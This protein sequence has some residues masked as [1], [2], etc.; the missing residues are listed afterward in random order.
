MQYRAILE[1]SIVDLQALVQ[2]E[3]EQNPLLEEVGHPSAEP[4]TTGTEN[5]A[6]NLVLPDLILQ[7]VGAEYVVTINHRPIPELR[8]SEHYGHLVA[9]AGA[10]AEVRDYVRE[11]TDAAKRLIESLEQRQTAL[12]TIGRAIVEFQRDFLEN[13]SRDSITPMAL[14]RVAVLVGLE[15]TAASH[16]DSSLF[17]V[18]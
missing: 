15:E 18:E 7:Q 4:T 9:E 10:S 14:P 1:L 11:K 5:I 13:R 16:S 8:I 3:L 12:L 17:S 2:S 6:G